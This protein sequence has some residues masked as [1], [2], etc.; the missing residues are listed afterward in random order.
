M[1]RFP[2]IERM[3]LQTIGM[4]PSSIGS[5][6]IARA[7]QARMESSGAASPDD[8]WLLLQRSPD[9]L[10][11]LIEAV[12]VSETWFFRDREPFSTLSQVV[13]SEWRHSHGNKR[14][15]ILSVPCATGEE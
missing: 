6:A 12:V 11:E 4:D 9:E 3:L 13:K 1:I 10:Q 5:P 2:D 7:A 14:L 15:R 8:Y